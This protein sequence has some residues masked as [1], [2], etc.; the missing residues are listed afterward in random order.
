MLWRH[1][2]PLSLHAVIHAVSFRRAVQY[3]KLFC[4]PIIPAPFSRGI[5]GTSESILFS[6]LICW[7]KRKLRTRWPSK[8]FP[9][10]NKQQIPC[11]LLRICLHR[12]GHNN[13]NPYGTDTEWPRSGLVGVAGRPTLKSCLSLIEARYR[14]LRTSYSIRLADLVSSEIFD[15]KSLLNI[16]HTLDNFTWPRSPYILCYDL[17][18]S[19]SP[20]AFKKKLCKTQ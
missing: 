15:A 2:Y 16:N 3:H 1:E 8:S 4:I 5:P 11:A 20:I 6:T 13:D 19:S 7:L 18:I 12:C 17:L 14:V 10:E 9:T